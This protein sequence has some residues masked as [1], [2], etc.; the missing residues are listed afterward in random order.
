VQTSDTLNF[1]A[2]GFTLKNADKDGGCWFLHAAETQLPDVLSGWVKRAYQDRGYMDLAQKARA[3]LTGESGADASVESV[4]NLIHGARVLTLVREGPSGC[5]GINAQILQMLR[6]R[7]G[8]AAQ[9]F[10]G[11][12]VLVTANDY[13]RQLFNGDVGLCLRDGEN[14]L[15]VVFERRG[16]S[17]EKRYRSYAA[18]TLY[19][20][21]LAFAM[22]VHKAQGSEFDEVLLALPFEGGERLLNRQMIYTAVT[23]ARTLALICG[24]QSVLKHALGRGVERCSGLSL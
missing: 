8:R 21:E 23:R 12:P 3:P 10:P 14:A 19:G 20:C 22:T 24:T 16:E 6:P 11:A 15:R 1:A 17:G 4:F 7:H 13:G 9:F 2:G 18:E 5:N